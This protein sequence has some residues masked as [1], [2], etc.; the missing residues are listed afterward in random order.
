VIV[1]SDGKAVAED[2]RG[3][4]WISGTGTWLE[5]IHQRLATS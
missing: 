2:R 5:L 1:T 4:R 3:N